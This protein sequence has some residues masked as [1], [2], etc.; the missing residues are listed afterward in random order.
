MDL[1]ANE[2]HR[3]QGFRDNFFLFT[4]GQ[5]IGKVEGA[6]GQTMDGAE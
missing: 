4:F 1:V 3:A 2:G 5:A 6:G